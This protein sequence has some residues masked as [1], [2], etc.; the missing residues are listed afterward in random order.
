MDR[1]TR[2]ALETGRANAAEVISFRRK[3]LRRRAQALA[4]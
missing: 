2:Q 3:A 4:S 1:T